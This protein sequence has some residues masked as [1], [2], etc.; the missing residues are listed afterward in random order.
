M[1]KKQPQYFISTLGVHQNRTDFCCG[2]ESLDIYLRKYAGQD[3]RKHVTATF[4]LL[5]EDTVTI[6]GYYTLSAT[7]I[8]L[9]DLPVDIAKNFPKYPF[10]PATLLGRLAVDQRFHGQGLG[11]MLLMDALYRSLLHS[12]EIA[13]M[14]VVVEAVNEESGAFYQHFGF[15]PFPDTRQKLFLPMRNIRKLFG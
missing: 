8:K 6:T 12:R 2:I 3:I 14:A 13:S 5:L 11:E 15:K 9:I 7:G 1:N 4:V 10:I